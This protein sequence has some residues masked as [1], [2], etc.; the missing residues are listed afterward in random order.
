[1]PPAKSEPVQVVVTAL[2]HCHEQ[3]EPPAP[4]AAQEQEQFPAPSM[5]VTD[6]TVTPS[7]ESEPELAVVT[8]LIHCHK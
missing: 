1:M 2:V 6:G 4:L 8:A 7:L 5:E 3:E